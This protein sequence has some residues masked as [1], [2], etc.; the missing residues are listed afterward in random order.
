MIFLHRQNDPKNIQFNN[1]NGIEIDIRSLGSNLIVTHDRFYSTDFENID[2]C[3]CLQDVVKYLRDYTVIV[4]VKESGLEEQISDI[5]DEFGSIKYYFLDSQIPDIL[6]L[7]KQEKYRGKFI[8]RVSDYETL[9]YKFLS[10][11]Q[12]EFIWV[13]YN[14]SNFDNSKILEYIKFLKDIDSNEYLSQ[15]GI[16]KILVSPELYGL[17]NINITSDIIKITNK[18]LLKKYSICTKLP[19]D[20][21]KIV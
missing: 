20:W 3:I 6:R 7:S 12:P 16:K 11:C 18:E 2:D 5:L 19:D 9:N 15:N 14:F 8:I 4:N 21:R 10:H 17:Q 1:I 13:D